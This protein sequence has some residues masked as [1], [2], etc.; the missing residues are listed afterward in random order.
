MRRGG[1]KGG[2]VCLVRSSDRCFDIASILTYS[3]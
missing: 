1:V 2:E 3:Y